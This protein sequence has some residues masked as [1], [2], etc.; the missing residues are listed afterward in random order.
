M[1]LSFHP[2]A[3]YSPARIRAFGRNLVFGLAPLGTHRG[4]AVASAAPLSYASLSRVRLPGE[5]RERGQIVSQLDVS[6]GYFEVLGIAVVAGRTLESDDAG[7]SG[8]VINEAL[9]R[10]YWP[11][12]SPLGRT[13]MAGPTRDRET[14]RQVVGVVS[15]ADTEGAALRLE[16]VPP[17][18]HELL[19]ADS[20]FAARSPGNNE[21]AAPEILLRGG[22]TSLSLAISALSA[23]LDPL[24]KVRR[25]SLSSRF[26]ARFSEARFMAALAAGLGAT[27]LLLACVGVFGVFGYVV[28]QQTREIGIRLALGARA[29]HVIRSVL[30]VGGRALLIG[31][32]VGLGSAGAGAQVIRSAL[33]GQARS[34]QS[35]II[36]IGILAVAAIVAIAVRRGGRPGSI[37]LRL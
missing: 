32:A 36:V 8:I 13:V 20:A 31:L 15:D 5:T 30:N 7:T 27:A 19:T 26:D 16:P 23:E 18:M 29:D 1:V 4:L 37:P 24:V 3:S 17:R 2:P 35:R 21:R 12:E 6:P 25:T 11:G 22:D 10:R 9:A 33:H 34:T 14:A 28:R